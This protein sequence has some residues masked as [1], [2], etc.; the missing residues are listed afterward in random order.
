MSRPAGVRILP[1]EAPAPSLDGDEIHVWRLRYRHAQRRKPLTALLGR[2]LQVS[3]DHVALVDDEHGRPRL[4]NGLDPSLD[5]NWS[6]SG[7]LAVI[8]L[9]RGIAPGVDIERRRARKRSLDI[10]RRFFT[11]EEANTLAALSPQERDAGFLQL[12]TA[13]E[14]VLKAI[15]RGIAFGLQRLDIVVENGQPRLS[16]LDGD[17][18]AAWQL[19]ALAFDP[20][21]FGTLAWRG[22]ERYVRLF[23]LDPDGG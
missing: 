12:W 10:A 18:P 5:F 11:A 15:G 1:P 4:A 22:G 8:A 17:D 16:R 21:L 9:A 20:T 19:R 3:D 6:H 2:Y 23:A 14:A 13:K 7:D